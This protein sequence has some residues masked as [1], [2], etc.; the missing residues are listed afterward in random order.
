[1]IAPE[2]RRY[3]RL[4]EQSN[5]LIRVSRRVGPPLTLEDVDKL[6]QRIR[7]D[8]AKL[9][10]RIRGAIRQMGERRP[11]DALVVLRDRSVITH[12]QY[13][14]WDRLRNWAAHAGVVDSD[15]LQ[16][17]ITEC[18][19]VYEL[20][21]IL[22]FIAVGYTG[23]YRQTSLAGW[24]VGAFSKTLADLVPACIAELEQEKSDR[25]SLP[26]KAIDPEK[27]P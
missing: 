9:K 4:Q 17:R 6:A 19:K 16:P 3:L 14:A 2:S 1:M 26:G 25:E 21:L 23:K 22:T 11:K 15:S 18:F 27:P 10:E 13:K 5:P 8:D 24:P 7:C 12:D 20:I